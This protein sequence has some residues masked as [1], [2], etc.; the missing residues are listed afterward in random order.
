[1]RVKQQIDNLLGGVSQAPPWQRAANEVGQ[2]VNA[3]PSRVRGLVKRPPLKRLSPTAQ[4][5]FGVRSSHPIEVEGQRYHAVFGQSP[6][7]VGIISATTG[8]AIPVQGGN[9]DYLQGT[10]PMRCV[11]VGLRTYVLN[12]EVRVQEHPA[13]ISPSPSKLNEALIWVRSVVEG[14]DEYRAWITG[15]QAKAIIT[16]T[17]ANPAVF[18]EQLADHF[19]RGDTL[20]GT[21]YGDVVHVRRTSGAPLTV[22][23]SAPDG[24]EE[25]I[26]II[27]GVARDAGD[28]PPEAPTGFVVEV[29]GDPTSEVDNYYLEKTDRGWQE[30]VKPGEGA[31]LDGDTMPHVLEFDPDQFLWTFGPLDWEMRG[32]GSDLTNPSPSFVGQR[33]TDVFYSEGRLGLIVGNKVVMSRSGEPQAFFRETV[34]SYRDNAPID[35]NVAASE[36]D[37]LHAALEWNERPYLFSGSG[38]YV[39]HGDP[40][41]TP[42]TVSVRRVGRFRS[43]RR[44]RPVLGTDS[45]FLASETPSGAQVVEFIHSEEYPAHARVLTEGMAGYVRGKPIA[46]AVDP[47]TQFL[48]LATDHSPYTL[49]TY[50]YDFHPNGTPLLQSWGKWELPSTVEVR[51]LYMSEGVLQVLFGYGIVDLVAEMDVRGAL[52]SGVPIEP[53]L[54]STN[55]TMTVRLSPIYLR[56]ELGRAETKG[57]LNVTYVDFGLGPDTT[58]V[59]CTVTR[60]GRPSRTTQL[61]PGA[62]R[63]P[64]M[65]EG[66]KTSLL[67]TCPPTE[68]C[69]ITGMYWEGFYNDTSQ[70]V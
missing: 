56:D 68:D 18:A 15:D 19:T 38:V 48:A 10:T 61:T 70:R 17:S 21:A 28:L 58:S 39:L 22:H 54:E 25:S 30:V 64:L 2:M 26:V 13:P 12:P 49:Y 20:V 27:Q 59:S 14:S 57:H 69:Q 41:L 46:M 6:G 5:P 36:A 34:R 42:K 1:M 53:D 50:T 24:A 35:I 62:S 65:G 52:G 55:Y 51:G 47:D 23:V 33:L 16:A 40:I 4:M 60:E 43:T 7:Q 31:G 3:L 32:A 9:S 29:E 37:S 8:T 11:T 67:L 66:T 45:I 63:L 44:F